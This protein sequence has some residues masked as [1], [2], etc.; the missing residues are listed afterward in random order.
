VDRSMSIQ[1]KLCLLH[2]FELTHASLSHPNQRGRS[3]LIEN[4]W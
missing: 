3:S 2:R 4:W 1:K